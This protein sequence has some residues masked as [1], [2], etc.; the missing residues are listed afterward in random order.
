MKCPKCDAEISDKETVCRYCNNVIKKENKTRNKN[1]NKSLGCAI[2]LL[3]LVSI[4]FIPMI[5]NSIKSN[6]IVMHEA[7]LIEEGKTVSA[8][9]VINDIVEVLKNRD[10]EKFETYLDE[11]FEYFGN[12]N[13]NS[14]HT[15]K[16]WSE[17]K[18]LS[19][20]S[21]D[22]EKRSNSIKDKETYTIYWNVVDA[23]KSLGRAHQYYC[24]QKITI[25]LKK[26]IKEDI[27]TYSIEKIILT[28]N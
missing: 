9:T 10:K 26:E 23:N 14:K 19:E 20:E 8:D 3:I 5:V 16:L 17:L 11:N 6:S 12:D 2:V 22:I 13:N 21:Y 15:W 18:Y 1:K 4:I 28:D 7:K 27:I 25:M 24:L